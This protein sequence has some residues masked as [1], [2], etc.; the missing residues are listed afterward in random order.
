MGVV[1]VGVWGPRVLAA[2]G[3]FVASRFVLFAALRGFVIQT[4]ST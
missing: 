4:P 3:A 1:A 2:T